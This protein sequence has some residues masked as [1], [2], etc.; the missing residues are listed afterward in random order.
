MIR[1]PC[2]NR[3]RREGSACI[4]LMPSDAFLLFPTTSVQEYTR[5]NS[6]AWR[7]AP[8][9]YVLIGNMVLG[10]FRSRWGH[11]PSERRKVSA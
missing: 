3:D 5:G 6:A 10:G 2:G 9:F 4:L 7:S 11:S 8:V 1:L